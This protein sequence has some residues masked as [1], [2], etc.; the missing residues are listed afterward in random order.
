[1][2]NKEFEYTFF[3]YGGFRVSVI[4]NKR[5]EHV[6]IFDVSSN[7]NERFDKKTQDF[8]KKNPDKMMN[9]VDGQIVRIK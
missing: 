1:M 4:Y 8:F 2:E 3:Y 7:N 5:H 9:L 6:K